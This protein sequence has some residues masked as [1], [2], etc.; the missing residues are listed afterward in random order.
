MG[1]GGDEAF[2]VLWRQHFA[3]VARVASG[4][5]A[6]AED[7]ADVAQEAFARAYQH[8]A[9]VSRLERPDAWVH[10]VA[11]NLA[12][13]RLRRARRGAG[14]SRL[15]AIEQPDLPDEGLLRALST[16]TPAQR[17]VVVLRFYLDL[18]VEEVAQSL[19]KKPGTVRALTHQGVERLRAALAKEPSD[20]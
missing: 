6:S 16:L 17:A 14:F 8:W 7:G 20:G 5:T 11:I 2:E 10:R 3:A 18:S 15:P 1:S 4:V 9:K 12:I 13:S 19:E